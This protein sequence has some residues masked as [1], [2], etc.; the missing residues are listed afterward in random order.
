MDGIKTFGNDGVSISG[1]EA[2]NFY[3]ALVLKGAIGLLQKG[4]TPTRG[5]TMTKALKLATG[6]T[7]KAYKRT[8]SDLAVLE[9]QT[10]ID[11]ERP[12][13]PFNDEGEMT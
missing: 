2:V 7:G 9:L 3:R 5:L 10:W 13:I 11:N 12:N 6:Y 8:Q 4:I 1:N